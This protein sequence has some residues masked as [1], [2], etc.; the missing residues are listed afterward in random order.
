MFGVL[1]KVPSRLSIIGTNNVS[2]YRNIAR[3]IDSIG[4]KFAPLD[5]SQLRKHSLSLRYEA[6]AG[7]PLWD[8][9]PEAYALV[10]EASTRVLNMRHYPVQLIGGIAM[11][12]DNIVVMQTGEGKT[13]TATL[14]MYLAA[15]T[16]NGAHLATA[17]D[18][19][20]E[21]DAE[22][23]R[24]VYEFLG[25]SIGTVSPM[26][27]TSPIR[28]PKKS[29]SISCGTDCSDGTPTKPGDRSSPRSP[30]DLPTPAIRFSAG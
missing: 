1:N 24:S 17:N 25:M 23:M 21:R 13:L 3:R 29:D 10:R 18:Y 15:L 19:L 5:E 30:V 14:P 26:R 6:L 8:L 20:A 7:K 28:R 12:D 2:K 9:L 27:P 16:Q 11:F 22:L 4:K